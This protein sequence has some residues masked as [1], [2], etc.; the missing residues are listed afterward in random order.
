MLVKA[1]RKHPWEIELRRVLVL[2]MKEREQ[3]KLG[4]ERERMTYGFHFSS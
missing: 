3:V 4:E 1:A 2:G